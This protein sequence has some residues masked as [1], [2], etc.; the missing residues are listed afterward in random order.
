MSKHYAK[1]NKSLKILS[2]Q[3]WNNGIKLLWKGLV[4]WKC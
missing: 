3:G 1:I 2:E 4:M